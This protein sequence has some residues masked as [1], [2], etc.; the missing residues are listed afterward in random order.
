MKTIL[1]KITALSFFVLFFTLTS[2]AQ[3]LT[4]KT[5]SLEGAK[6]VVEAA[7]QSAKQLNAPGGSFAIVDAGG[8]LILLERIDGTF[9]AA[10]EVAIK[11]ANTAATFKAP[12]KKLEDAVNGGRIALATVGHTFLQGGQPILVDGQVVGA[13]GISGTASGEQDEQIALLASKALLQ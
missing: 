10:S 5:L 13:I 7:K 3:V 4:V 6:K 1:P 9:P 2:N 8:N 12:T 11:K